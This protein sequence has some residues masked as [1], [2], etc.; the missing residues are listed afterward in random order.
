[1]KNPRSFCAIICLCA[2][3]AVSSVSFSTGSFPQAGSLACEAGG[4]FSQIVEMVQGWFGGG[5]ENAE[6][7]E[8][9]PREKTADDN[10]FFSKNPFTYVTAFW[11]EIVNAPDDRTF[12]QRILAFL[13]AVR[14]ER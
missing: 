6:T 1:M 9:A 12:M 10:T 13:E 8:P 3:L 14:R 5:D 2:L 11:T 7:P 4:V